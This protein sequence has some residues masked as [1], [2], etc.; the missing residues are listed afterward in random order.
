MDALARF[1]CGSK[2]LC[3]NLIVDIP[4]EDIAHTRLPGL[5]AVESADDS[6]VHDSAHSRHLSED[7][8]VHNVAGAGTHNRNHLP[9]LGGL[10]GRSGNVGIHV[11]NSDDDSLG[12]PGP[13]C[14]FG[15]QNPGWRGELTNRVAYLVIDEAPETR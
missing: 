1:G 14:R 12:K 5:V 4:G 3:R 15:S 2:V 8:T 13:C 7:F 10:G 11:S 9:G 6:A